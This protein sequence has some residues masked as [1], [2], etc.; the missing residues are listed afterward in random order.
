MKIRFRHSLLLLLLF[1]A[2][3]LHFLI[4]TLNYITEFFPQKNDPHKGVFLGCM[5]NN[6]TFCKDQ[7]EE[8]KFYT[9]GYINRAYCVV[10]NENVIIDYSPLKLIAV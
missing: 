1:T 8:V 4:M 6:I 7:A 5:R 2:R 9:L 3:D 10:V